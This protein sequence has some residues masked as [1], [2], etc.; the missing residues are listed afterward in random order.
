MQT[1]SCELDPIP[2]QI[3]KQVLSVL[4][5][6]ITHIINASLSSACFCEEWKTSVVRPLLK[7][8]GLDLLEKNYQPV[9]N[10]PFLSK[11]VE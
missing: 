4:I 1:K 7:K 9:S 8:R 6:L 5:P 2:M 11:L 10:L 3:L